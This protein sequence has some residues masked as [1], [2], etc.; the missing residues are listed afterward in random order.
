[1][2][3]VYQNDSKDGKNK[4]FF[5]SR[6]VNSIDVRNRAYSVLDGLV[7]VGEALSNS[8][9]GHFGKSAYVFLGNTIPTWYKEIVREGADLKENPIDPSRWINEVKLLR[10]EVSDTY[11][12]GVASEIISRIASFLTQMHRVWVGPYGVRAVVFDKPRKRMLTS[13]FH[14]IDVSKVS[15]KVF[16]ID[17]DAM[18]GTQREKF[19]EL[20][21][22]TDH[23]ALKN[24][25]LPLDLRRALIRAKKLGCTVILSCNSPAS[26]AICE[27]NMRKLSGKVCINANNG[28]FVAVPNE[29]GRLEIIND[30]SLQADFVDK[31][32]SFVK[33]EEGKENYFDTVIKSKITD[34]DGVIQDVEANLEW[35]VVIEDN[36]GIEY[37]VSLEDEANFENLAKIYANNDCKSLVFRPH[38]TNYSQLANIKGAP[39]WQSEI[40][41]IAYQAAYAGS[42]AF[43]ASKM[44]RGGELEASLQPRSDGS[45]SVLNHEFSCQ[46]GVDTILSNLDLG[47]DVFSLVSTTEA[48]SEPITIEAGETLFES[49]KRKKQKSLKQLAFDTQIWNSLNIFNKLPVDK[50]IQE[51][52]TQNGKRKLVDN[53]KVVLCGNCGV[54]KKKLGLSIFKNF[55]KDSGA[56]VQASV[57]NKVGEAFHSPN[58]VNGGVNF[59]ANSLTRSK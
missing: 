52:T 55:F 8:K 37:A 42:A 2:K 15:P 45:F 56:K 21:S 53:T 40:D 23:M 13:I 3:V 19:V 4:K 30:I 18:P 32:V 50:F 33:K 46:K 20:L 16:N 14:S 6:K 54:A 26:R 24:H 44:D 48:I 9:T 57:E 25:E 7:S 39:L 51:E 5:A 27:A 41:D 36:S 59:V 38:I 43:I 10:N 11:A 31:V 47:E 35:Y 34:N 49:A 12:F 58:I 1:M 28:A 17:L 22:A 29:K